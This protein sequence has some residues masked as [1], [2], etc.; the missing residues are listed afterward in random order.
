MEVKKKKNIC[1]FQDNIGFDFET[2]WKT[3]D[4]IFCSQMKPQTKYNF[5]VMD[6]FW[7]SKNNICAFY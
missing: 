7:V 2:F 1:F 3:F 4:R 6:F 5:M